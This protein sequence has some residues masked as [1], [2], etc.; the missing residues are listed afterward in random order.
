[1]HATRVLTQNTQAGRR[2]RPDSGLAQLMQPA[3]P[4]PACRSCI[5]RY[6]G[7]RAS[8]TAIIAAVCPGGVM[9]TSVPD[10][11]IV[12]LYRL[13]VKAIIPSPTVSRTSLPGPAPATERTEQRRR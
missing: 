1:M 10:L 6:A 2:E 9:S 11:L 8:A 13:A 12:R 3:G 7:A 4:L 5:N